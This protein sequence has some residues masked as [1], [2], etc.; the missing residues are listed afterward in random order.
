MVRAEGRVRH[1]LALPSRI[2]GK[3]GT[4]EL[5]QFM[6]YVFRQVHEYGVIQRKDL[7]KLRWKETLQRG[8]LLIY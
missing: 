5:P 7:E 2:L 6:R 4:Q 3:G 1:V 8:P